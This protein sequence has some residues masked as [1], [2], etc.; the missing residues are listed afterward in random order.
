[1]SKTGTTTLKDCF[2]ELGL[3]PHAGFN[4]KFK[5]DLSNARNLDNIIKYAHGYKSFQD[6]PWYLLYK[7]LDIAYPNSKFILT[8]RKDSMTHTLSSWNHNV[9]KG[10]RKGE[11]NLQYIKDKISSYENHNNEVK[12]YFQKRKNDLL[13]LCWEKEDGW[14][15]LCDFLGLPVPN[16][17]IPHLNKGEDIKNEIKILAST[18]NFL[19]KTFPLK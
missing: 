14:E 7:E 3:L 12:K 9:K 10:R 13:I 17:S 8:V 11:P 15:K 1:M 2:E 6:N 5:N 4:R 18:R 16:K 19:K